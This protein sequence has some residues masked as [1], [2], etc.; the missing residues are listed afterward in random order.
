MSLLRRDF[1]RTTLLAPLLG[2]IRREPE[3]TGMLI[4][5]R[6]VDFVAKPGAPWA[7]AFDGF[8]AAFDSDGTLTV[9]FDA[10]GWITDD[11]WTR[12]DSW[13]PGPSMQSRAARVTLTSTTL[14]VVMWGEV[15]GAPPEVLVFEAPNGPGRGDGAV[16][17]RA[18]E[19]GEHTL[20]VERHVPAYP[21]FVTVDWPEG[22]GGAEAAR[23][24]IHEDNTQLIG[25]WSWTQPGPRLGFATETVNGKP[26]GRVVRSPI[27]VV[28]GPDRWARFGSGPGVQ[29]DGFFGKLPPD[30][31]A[32]LRA[33]R[34]P[35]GAHPR[36]GWTYTPT[37]PAK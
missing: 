14:T 34:L 12:F 7:D 2:L 35:P 17:T 21:R 31:S 37:E 26:G 28:T 20:V 10:S 4:A 8:R 1:I 9:R 32:L 18:W 27:R 19:E 3:P 11:S 6:E 16:H 15:V 24:R 25:D 30:T 23:V 33:S 13:R 29:P 36:P 22:V 5:K